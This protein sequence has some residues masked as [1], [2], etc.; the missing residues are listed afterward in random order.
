MDHSFLKTDGEFVDPESGRPE[1]EDTFATTLVMVDR[2]T[3]TPRAIALT[4]TT[5]DKY[6]RDAVLDFVG[7]QKHRTLRI[8]LR[9]R[10]V[11]DETQA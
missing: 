8:G 5:S 6:C 4:S 2:D 11:A 3:R 1:V 9:P 7:R 10:S